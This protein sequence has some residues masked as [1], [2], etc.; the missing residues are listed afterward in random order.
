MFWD[1]D[2]FVLPALA[3]LRPGAARAMLEYRLTACPRRAAAASRG[4]RGARFPWESA[5]DG[6]DVTP[7]RVPGRRG[8]LV[9]VLTGED[10]EHI[11]GDVAWAACRCAAWTGD[12]AFLEGPGRA[13]LV[14]TAR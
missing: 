7:D 13:L 10:Q 11:V 8:E 6:S 4:R 14:E 12:T 3:A 9:P 2:V 1:A 5:G